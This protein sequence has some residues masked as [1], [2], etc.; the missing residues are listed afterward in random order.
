MSGG[1]EAGRRWRRAASPELSRED[2]ASE[3]PASLP[4]A[5]EC[6]FCERT[7]TELHSVFGSHASVSTYW[8]RT[9]RSPFEL[10]KWRGR[11]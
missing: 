1:R 6:P 3:A 8:C 7:D 2:R 5:P 11:A 4:S 10:V 9:C